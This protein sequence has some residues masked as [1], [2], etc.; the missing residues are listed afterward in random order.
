M[1]RKVKAFYDW[2]LHCLSTKRVLLSTQALG[3]T[4]ANGLQGIK[5]G[6]YMTD[7]YTAS[8]V[9]IKTPKMENTKRKHLQSEYSFEHFE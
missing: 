3:K 5:T 1:S 6:I 4:F 7:L 8:M 2:H 9:P